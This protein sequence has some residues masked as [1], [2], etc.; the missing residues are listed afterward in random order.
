MK[1]AGARQTASR[2]DPG[3]RKGASA[4][5]SP[6]KRP[7]GAQRTPRNEPEAASNNQKDASDR[8]KYMKKLLFPMGLAAMA[9]VPSH[10]LTHAHAGALRAD[11]AD[12]FL[13]RL[14]KS[15]A[16]FTDVWNDFVRANK[17][18]RE[19]IGQMTA[20]R[21]LDVTHN[22]QEE[23]VMFTA[24][25]DSPISGRHITWSGHGYSLTVREN[26]TVVESSTNYADGMKLHTLKAG[27]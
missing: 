5:E 16:Q 2:L 25:P 18:A 8:G 3:K 15:E 9:V 7:G 11:T 20:W 14:P 24:A 10:L 12:P 17:G 6:F 26:G 23:A 1:S 19:Q 13:D 21:V 4:A 22:E 27:W